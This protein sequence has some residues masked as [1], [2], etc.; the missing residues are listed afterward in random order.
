M[1][2]HPKNNEKNRPKTIQSI[3]KL[4]EKKN[5]LHQV[6]NEIHKNQ[7]KLFFKF[8]CNAPSIGS[9]WIPLFSHSGQ[10]SSLIGNTVYVCGEIRFKVVGYWK[11]LELFM[12]LKMSDRIRTCD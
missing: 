7:L 12:T 5:N 3:N 6:R 2:K 10:S 8:L 1:I 11:I 9:T 4:F